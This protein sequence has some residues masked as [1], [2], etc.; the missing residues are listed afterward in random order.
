MW[1]YQLMSS[2]TAYGVNSVRVIAR[3]LA[4][5]PEERRD[6]DVERGRSAAVHAGERCR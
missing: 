5:R 6:V 2:R 1:A 3:S 4:R